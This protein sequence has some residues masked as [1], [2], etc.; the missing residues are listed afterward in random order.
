MYAPCKTKYKEK[1]AKVVQSDE[2]LF[3]SMDRLQVLVKTAGTSLCEKVQEKVISKEQVQ[4]EL[5]IQ[6]F[7]EL[8]T[9]REEQIE[10]P[11]KTTVASAKE[12]ELEDELVLLANKLLS[13]RLRRRRLSKSQ[14]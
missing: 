12:Q 4:L 3:K 6:I 2:G 7:K 9:S 11:E 13:L 14:N 1:E 8:I 10:K 5:L